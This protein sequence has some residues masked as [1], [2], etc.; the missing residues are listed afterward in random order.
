MA[1]HKDKGTASEHYMPTMTGDYSR[2]S[3]TAKAVDF[4][5]MPVILDYIRSIAPQIIR[6]DAGSPFVIADYGAAD[7]VNS[8]VLFEN[9]I[10]QIRAINPS[11]KIRLVYNDIAA[12][13]YFDQF[14][15]GSRLKQME[16]VEVEYIRRSF[17]KAIH[18]IKG[19][20]NLGFSSTSLH[21]LDTEEV[22][23]DFF[24]HPAHIQA[25][26]LSD[27]DRRKFVDKWK[28][29]WR[30]FLKERAVELVKGGALFMA[31]LTN[32][33]G[34]RWPAS[35]GYN[36]LRDICHDLCREGKIREEEWTAIF[37][38]DYFATPQEMESLLQED[39]LAKVFSLG[40]FEEMTVPCA[41]YAQFKD[42]LNDEQA[43]A[44][45]ADTLA[46]VVRAWSESSIKTGLA[47]G[48]KPE[49]E[50]IY[51]RLRDKFYHNPTGL[52]YEYCLTEL[53]KK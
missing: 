13:D 43:K 44:K 52:P 19:K 45:L 20:L 28:K 5:I 32:R 12:Q 33:G 4:K 22:G 38:P 14:W 9:I 35:A 30:T 18:E 16:G 50:E 37:V 10:G 23:T 49:I 27:R 47:A 48:D 8:S 53:K 29:D 11:L 26:Q 3:D 42:K 2:I 46:H 21:W 6:M 17:Y 24:Q 34:D 40:F 41:Y 31:N 1:D 25:N 39:G 7:G 15:A 36:N 51:Q